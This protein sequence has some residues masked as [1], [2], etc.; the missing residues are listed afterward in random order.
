VTEFL[1]PTRPTSGHRDQEAD[2]GHDVPG[3]DGVGAPSAP[4]AEPVAA[5][6]EPVRVEVARAA[7]EV[8]VL[9]VDHDGVAAVASSAA[10]TAC[11]AAPG[12]GRCEE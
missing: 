10:T 2:I 1:A 5:S 4:G 9:L 3:R 12:V 6:T 7:I 8:P 11:P